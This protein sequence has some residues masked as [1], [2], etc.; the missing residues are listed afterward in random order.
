VTSVKFEDPPGSAE[1][2]PTVHVRGALFGDMLVVR[3]VVPMEELVVFPSVHSLL[4]PPSQLR[5]S[6][7]TTCE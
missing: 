3:F 2:A 1:K 5:T 6:H 4:A 7:P